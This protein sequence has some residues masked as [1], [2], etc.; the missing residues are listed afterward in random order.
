M[1]EGT[2][3]K[4][5]AHPLEQSGPDMRIAFDSTIDERVAAHMR[6]YEITGMLRRQKW[7]PLMLA[8]IGA[9]A[10]F[11]VLPGST[12][13]RLLFALF[14]AIAFTALHLA[15]YRMELK[16]QLKRVL[17]RQLKTAEAIP[18]GYELNEKGI[19]FRQLGIE[20]GFERRA[21]REILEAGDALEFIV[22]PAGTSRIPDRVFRDRM[23]RQKWV[24]FRRARMAGVRR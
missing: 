3:E 18:G 15:F 12:G 20:V 11:F 8:P 22:F 4:D 21:V 2:S 10:C 14:F 24:G 9:V 7:L 16:R 19:V 13:G 1:S 17:I 6:L 23:E 5:E